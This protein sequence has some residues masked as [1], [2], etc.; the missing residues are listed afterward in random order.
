MSSKRRTPI[1][2]SSARSTRSRTPVTPLAR[3]ASA[4]WQ[5]GAPSNA[6]TRRLAARPSPGRLPQRACA[7]ARG[8]PA[9][10]C[11]ARGAGGGAAAPASG[12]PRGAR[13]G[14]RRWYQAVRAMRA[15]VGC[16]LRAAAL[17]A[18]LRGAR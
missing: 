5:S 3:K 2:A 1:C 16:G 6:Q 10:A 4:C 11:G 8:C 9:L 14:A 15:A 7:A 17:R 18:A 13:D 12:C